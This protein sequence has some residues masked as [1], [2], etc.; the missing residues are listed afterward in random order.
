VLD[1]F[2]RVRHPTPSFMET[3]NG[4]VHC[5]S[6]AVAVGRSRAA[7]GTTDNVLKVRPSFIHSEFGHC[8][9]QQNR[10]AIDVSNCKLFG[11]NRTRRCRR[12]PK[13]SR[14]LIVSAARVV[15]PPGGHVPGQ[16]TH[17]APRISCATR[18]RR[19]SDG[20]QA[21]WGGSWVRKRSRQRGIWSGFYP[22]PEILTQRNCRTLSGSTIARDDGE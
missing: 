1:A 18:H 2:K 6:S 22:L 5:H 20:V 21:V 4:R 10:F 14:Q 7:C 12:R 19:K 13:S 11:R 3:G 17:S 9:M 8:R 15:D 16:D